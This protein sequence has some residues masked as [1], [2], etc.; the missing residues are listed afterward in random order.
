MTKAFELN[1]TNEYLINLL[2]NKKLSY[3]QIYSFELMEL[4]M[5]KFY[6]KANLSNSFIKSFKLYYY[7]NTIC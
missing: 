5:L 3:S 2:N 1:K 6:I 7:S 4:K